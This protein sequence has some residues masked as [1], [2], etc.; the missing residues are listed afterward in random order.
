[1]ERGALAGL[2]R[3]PAEEER[4]GPRDAKRACRS[5]EAGPGEDAA[6]G[7]N[8]LPQGCWITD[9][10]SESKGF[11]AQESLPGNIQGRQ[12]S[13]ISANNGRRPHQPC[14]RCLAGQSGHFNHTMNC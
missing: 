5:M 8:E 1:M 12:S 11:V 2:R 7:Q 3:R 14:S 4:G 13:V 10:G 6:P 9:W